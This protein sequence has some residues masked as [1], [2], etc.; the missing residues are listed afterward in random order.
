M[1]DT[2]REEVKDEDMEVYTIKKEVDWSLYSVT[3]V[4]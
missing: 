3:E 4:F 1:S 2:K